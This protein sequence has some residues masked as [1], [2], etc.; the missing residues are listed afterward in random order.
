VTDFDAQF[1]LGGRNF[2]RALRDVSDK[3]LGVNSELSVH[4]RAAL[5]DESNSE[6][7]A[8]QKA[9]A[10]LPFATQEELLREVHKKLIFSA[11]GL[12]S[13]WPSEQSSKKKPSRH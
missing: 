13:A 5:S 2:L 10:A 6:I 11:D 7:G 12:L 3:H 1:A 8:V 4:A 9:L